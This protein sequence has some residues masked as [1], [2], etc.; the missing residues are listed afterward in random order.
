MTEPTWT[1]MAAAYVLDALDP[2]EARA[3]EAR[4]ATDRALQE[5][6]DAQR[7]V[8]GA[9]AHAAPPR[10]APAALRDRVLAEARSVRP[11]R[12]A[13][14]SVADAPAPGRRSMAPWF[15][16]AAATVA[17]VALGVTNRQLVERVDVTDDRLAELQSA[18]QQA[19]VEVAR[20][21]SL[22]ASLLGPDIRTASLAA[23]GAEPSARLYWN[24]ATGEVVVTAFGLP[25][26]P[27][28]RTYQL[29]GIG[30][31]ADPVSLGTFQTTA[32]G[33]AIVRASA[34]AGVAFDVSAMTE[35]PAGGS[36]QPTSTPFLVGTWSGD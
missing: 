29:W 1:D 26:A 22:L 3:F 18:V 11:I 7:E 6:V 20:R 4:L 27:D 10:D 13:R 15:L 17:A 30:E 19:G 14:D 16:A 35:E 12:S 25:P 32:D 28:G 8:L 23:T 5:E 34:P 33:T 36:P 24:G 31:G 2:E 21:D 9:L